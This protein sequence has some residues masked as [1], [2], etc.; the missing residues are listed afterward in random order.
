MMNMMNSEFSMMNDGVDDDDDEDDN[1]DDD[2]DNNGD[3]NDG[4]DCDEDENSH[5]IYPNVGLGTGHNGRF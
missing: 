1:G 4:D 3:D 2:D 5:S